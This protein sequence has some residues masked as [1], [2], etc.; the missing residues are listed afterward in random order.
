MRAQERRTS[1]L[2]YL[3]SNKLNNLRKISLSLS[4]Q[5]HFKL[6]QMDDKGIPSPEKHEKYTEKL[7]GGDLGNTIKKKLMECFEKHGC[8]LNQQVHN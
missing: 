4:S 2:T 8:K 7:A 5:I 6:W 3:N 1:K